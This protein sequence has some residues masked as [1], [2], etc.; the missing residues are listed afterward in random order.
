MCR[1]IYGWKN[2]ETYTVVLH[3]QNDLYELCEDIKAS[4]NSWIEFSDKLKDL[5]SH[6]RNYTLAQAKPNK[7]TVALLLDIGS[8]EDVDFD[9]IAKSFMNVK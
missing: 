6:L 4:S 5:F 7:K 1:E 9:Q 2:H 3:L 8:L